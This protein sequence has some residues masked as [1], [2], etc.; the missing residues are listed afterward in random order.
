MGAELISRAAK[1]LRAYQFAAIASGSL[2]LLY[3]GKLRLVGGIPRT[4]NADDAGRLVQ[5]GPHGGEPATDVPALDEHSRD[6]GARPIANP[7]ADRH[8]SR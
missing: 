2:A 8:E 7:D 3:W 1:R 6:Q 5:Q 4:V